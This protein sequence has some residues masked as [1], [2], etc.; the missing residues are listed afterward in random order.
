MAEIEVDIVVSCE[1]PDCESEAEVE[2]F[3]GEDSGT[4]EWECPHCKT[5]YEF[6]IEFLPEATGFREK[7]S[8]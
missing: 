5:K 3:N 6:E 1:N 4:F 7:E 8:N 2:C